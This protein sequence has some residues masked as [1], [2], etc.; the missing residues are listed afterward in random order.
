MDSTTGSYDET[1]TTDTT[2]S[3]DESQLTSEATSEYESTTS[4]PA[5]PIS[6]E[7]TE[8]LTE[9]TPSKE[10]EESELST[11]SDYP[12]TDATIS[13][14]VPVEPEVP[15]VD[16]FESPTTTT[17]TNTSSSEYMGSK[18][19]DESIDFAPPTTEDESTTEGITEGLQA[20]SLE[21]KA[22]FDCV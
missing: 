16:S 2:G 5:D 7:T 20:T 10:T 3:Y 12:A 15:Q 21:D 9:E 11:G 22:V 1:S 19:D 13:S 4:T 14:E 8:T 18:V 17:T 6:D